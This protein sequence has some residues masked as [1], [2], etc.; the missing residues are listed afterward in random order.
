MCVEYF[1]EGTS[2]TN[3]TYCLNAS[4]GS[5]N[6]GD[7]FL[8]DRNYDY[9]AEIYNIDNG[10]KT[11]LETYNYPSISS[12]EELFRENKLW[13]FLILFGTIGS[14][15]FGLRTKNIILT[16]FLNIVLS[17]VSLLIFPTLVFASVVAGNIV[18]N[19]GIFYV[20]RKRVDYS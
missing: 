10:R 16:C 12:A 15:V 20:A 2:I 8:L 17:I 13:A 4:S 18:L 3:T 9:S 14:M 7:Y 19:L 1:R 11:I 6:V 5:I